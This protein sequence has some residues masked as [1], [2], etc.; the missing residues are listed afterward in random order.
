MTYF[1]TLNYYDS[2]LK[3]QILSHEE[4]KWGEKIIL[5]I[6]QNGVLQS[7]KQ[8]SHHLLAWH[9]SSL[10][11]SIWRAWYI[12]LC[13]HRAL[14]FQMSCCQRGQREENL[15]PGIC[16]G[17][18]MKATAETAKEEG[19]CKL[20]CEGESTEAKMM[21]LP[22]ST[23]AWESLGDFGTSLGEDRVDRGSSAGKW[24]HSRACFP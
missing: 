14:T 22:W 10:L 1:T 8:Y 9:N 4:V 16:F 3:K 20:L 7:I 23:M 12:C 24:H 18:R 21:G 15:V 17:R 13:K 11:K 2:F 5:G 19:V 6:F